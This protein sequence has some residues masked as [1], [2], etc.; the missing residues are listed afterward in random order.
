M[1]LKLRLISVWLNVSN[2]VINKIL[3]H[4]CKIFNQNVVSQI[5]E[6]KM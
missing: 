2:E 4:C 3:Y 5:H 6:G 1:K